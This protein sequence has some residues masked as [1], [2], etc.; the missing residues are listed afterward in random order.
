MLAQLKTL[1]IPRTDIEEL[2]ALL[3]FANGMVTQYEAEELE[4]PEWL[5]EKVKVLGREIR[6]RS[7]DALM[8]KIKGA[9]SR[10]EAMKPA[11]TKRAELAKEIKRLEALASK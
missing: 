10:L 9:K 3:A 6:E 1:N 11:E 5:E 2:V 4:V 7:H 8:A